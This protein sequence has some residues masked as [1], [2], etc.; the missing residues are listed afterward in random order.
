MSLQIRKLETVRSKLELG[1]EFYN[2]NLDKNGGWAEIRTQEG[3][4]P[5]G[6]QDRC[7]QPL[8]HPSALR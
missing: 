5:A 4:R 6:F 8:C 3:L 1:F 2:E 7:I